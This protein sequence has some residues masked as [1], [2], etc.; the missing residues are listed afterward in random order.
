MTENEFR[1]AFHENKDAV[2]NFALRLTASDTAA[3]DLAQDCF[4]VLLRNPAKFNPARG[5]LR[6][7]LLGVTRNLAHRR[8]REERPTE[9]LDTEIQ[10]SVP[11]L[12]G[13]EISTLVSAAIQSLPP[14]QREVVLLFEYEGFTL[15]EI[16]GI[17]EADVG[18]VKSRLHRARE[19]LRHTLAPLRNGAGKP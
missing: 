13:G 3:E 4:L 2:Y 8:W 5:S 10:G 7:F 15:E 9:P 19:R 11:D 6:A 18:T 12:I 1:Q 16:A 17:A 14:L